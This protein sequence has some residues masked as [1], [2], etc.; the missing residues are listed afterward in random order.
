MSFADISNNSS[1]FRPYINPERLRH[2]AEDEDDERE[3]QHVRQ[4][5]QR[6]QKRRDD[7]YDHQ[8][9]IT[10]S[11]QEYLA[12]VV[13]EREELVRK[14]AAD[15]RTTHELM[16]DISRLVDEQGLWIGTLRVK[17]NRANEARALTMR[18]RPVFHFQIPLRP[19][20]RM[21]R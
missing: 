2:S 19:I 16:Q 11:E 5:L 15:M 6:I 10:Q 3:L 17:I 1:S 14:L 12:W 7:S 20:S 4:V 8:L 13:R 21:S 18:A 9:E